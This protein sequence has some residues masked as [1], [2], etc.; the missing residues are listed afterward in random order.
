MLIIGL[1]GGIGSGKSTVSALFEA[2]G[3]P[4]IDA[5]VIAHELVEPGQ[6]SLQLIIDAFGVGIVDATGCLNRSKLRDVIHADKS[7]KIRLESILHPRIK[8]EILN[9]V[10]KLSSDYCIIVVPLLLESGW[11]HLVDR[12]LVIDSTQEQQNE[13]IQLR[14]QLSKQQASTI[15]NNQSDRQNRL[16]AADDI[17]D[18]SG[19]ISDLIEQVERL[20]GLYLKLSQQ[21][22]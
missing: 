20:H 4:V 5:D 6:K 8:E 2:L 10:K 1:T 22:A 7:Q 13:R 12:I 21:T 17:I 16:A 14:D 18:N 3:V 19:E 11:Q 9:R 15:L